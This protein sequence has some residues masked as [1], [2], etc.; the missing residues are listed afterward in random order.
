MSGHPLI[1]WAKIKKFIKDVWSNAMGIV[2]ALLIGLLLGI[3]YKQDDIQEDCKYAGS[4]RVH[5]QAYNCQ[6]K[7]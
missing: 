1:E 3:V 2:V 6:R 5:T 7:I 4:F